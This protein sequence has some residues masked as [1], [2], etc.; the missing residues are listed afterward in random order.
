VAGRHPR[1]AVGHHVAV[2][3]D[4]GRGEGRAQLL[5]RQE[6]AVGAEVGPARHV[7]RAGHVA[8]A[9]VHRLPV[10][11]VALGVARVEHHRGRVEDVVDPGQP[12]RRPRAGGEHRWSPLRDGLVR[13][14]VPRRRAPVEQGRVV[15][16]DPQH[17]DQPGGDHP[18]GVVV[19][20]HGIVVPDA[21]RGH[22]LGEDLRLRQRV[23]PRVGPGVRGQPA[24][25]VDEDRTRQVTGVVGGAA[26]PAV[27]VPADVGEDDLVAV[28][29][30]PGRVHDGRQHGGDP[31]TASHCVTT[32]SQQVKPANRR[33]PVGGPHHR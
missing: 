19:G 33:P 27:E 5:D 21:E 15:P 20:H 11:A 4:P 8:G 17:P 7:D 13:R 10:P 6:A 14:P 30:Q 26:G 28:L 16:G 23:P 22:A 25:Q 24:V 1:A 29:A 32:R 3:G 12:L 31:T 2:G 18:A 9:R